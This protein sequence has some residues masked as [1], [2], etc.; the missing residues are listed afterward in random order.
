MKLTPVV[1]FSNVQPTAFAL[2]HPKSVRIQSSC[3]YLF[4]LLGS[5]GTKAARKT[6]VKLTS[7]Y[8]PRKDDQ[9]ETKGYHCQGSTYPSKPKEGKRG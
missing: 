4:T 1:D 3:Q 8:H 9:R 6:L 5:T 7:D 2:V